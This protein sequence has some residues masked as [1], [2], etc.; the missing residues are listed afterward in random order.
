M[1]SLSA[2]AAL[3]TDPTPAHLRR[4]ADWFEA[5]TPEALTQMGQC[6]AQEARFK[7]PFSEVHGHDAIRRVYAHMFDSL[8]RPRFTVSQ[9]MGQDGQGFLVWQMHFQFQRYHAGQDQC[10]KGVSHLR[11]NDEGMIVDHRDYWDAA[12]ELYEKLPGV[13]AIMRWLKRRA[14]G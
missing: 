11:L 13:G 4:I 2:T 9:C 6:Y 10:I 12:E 8:V 7:D 1:T 14:S 5:M 3:T